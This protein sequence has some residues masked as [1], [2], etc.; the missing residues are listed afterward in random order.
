MEYPWKAQSDDIGKLLLR[1]MVSGT[2]LFHGV[3]KLIHG[4]DWFVG[5]LG[6]AGLPGFFA[7]G[8]YV[9]EIIAP[10]LIIV[11][12]KTR[13]ASLTIAF[14][15]IVAVALVLYTQIFTVKEMG[16]GWGI[17]VEALIFFAALTLFFIGGRKYG[18]SNGQWD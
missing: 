12:Y 14:N 3:A 1:I 18:I 6:Q 2:L 17:E 10:F 11:G 16:G 4:V 7:Y 15:M 13:L 5:M 8:V 9:A